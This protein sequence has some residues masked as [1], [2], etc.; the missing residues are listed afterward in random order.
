[1]FGRHT[2]RPA[3]QDPRSAG[4]RATPATGMRDVVPVPVHSEAAQYGHAEDSVIGRDDHFE[5]TL[6]TQKS[7]RVLGRFQG[8]IEAAG[9]VYVEEGGRVDADVITDEA[10]I[11]GQYS[12]KLICRQRLEIRSTGLAKGEIETVSLMLHEGGFIDGGLHMQRPETGSG[13][14]RS[15]A[16]SIRGEGVAPTAS[17]ETA[18]ATVSGRTGSRNSTSID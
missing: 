13:S 6:R 1:M 12:G 3:A 2:D 16:G 8:Q 7:V 10:I 5:G 18:R 17:V 4:I 15:D 11:A 14:V 9:S